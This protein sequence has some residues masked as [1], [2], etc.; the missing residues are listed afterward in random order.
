MIL[1]TCMEVGDSLYE[2]YEHWPNIQNILLRFEPPSQMLHKLEISNAPLIEHTFILQCF[3][4][5]QLYYY[6]Y[7]YYF[8]LFC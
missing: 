3:L 5:L 6:Y 8:V 1:C 4:L 7:Y 2:N